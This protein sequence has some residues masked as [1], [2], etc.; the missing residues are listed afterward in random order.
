[1]LSVLLLASPLVDLQVDM[2][3]VAPDYAIATSKEQVFESI[4]EDTKNYSGQD[5]EPL[6]YLGVARCHGFHLFRFVIRAS[7]YE[8]AYDIMQTYV[9]RINSSVLMQE[10]LRQGSTLFMG[11]L[12]SDEEANQSE[13]HRFVESASDGLGPLF[14]LH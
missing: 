4:E 7:S 8:Q 6:H 10:K 14:V 5:L 9:G 11:G 1:M 12:V 2:K 3:S 13:L